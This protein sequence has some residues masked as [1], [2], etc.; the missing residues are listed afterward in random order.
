MVAIS[1]KKIRG[2]FTLGDAATT[3]TDKGKALEDLTCYVF[4]KIPGISVTARNTLNMFDT[5]EIDVAF[6]NEQ[7]PNGLSFLPNI[8]LVECKNWSNAVGSSEV[9]WFDRKLE[10]HGQSFGILIA[11]NGITGNDNERNRAHEIVRDALKQHRKIIIITKSELETLKSTSDLI[12]LIKT[13]LCQ[14]AVSGAI[15]N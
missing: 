5:E 10:N 14:L 6:W 4:N 1:N 7:N 13:K 9:S 15:F 8:I 2:F 12:L 3:T 11:A